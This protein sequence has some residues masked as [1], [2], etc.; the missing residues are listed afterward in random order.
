MAGIRFS[1]NTD[2]EAFILISPVV[3]PVYI[4]GRKMSKD[5]RR[6]HSE[7][8]HQV[9]EEEAGKKSVFCFLPAFDCSN[10]EYLE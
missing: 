1:S 3:W 5:T 10:T 8:I 9:L 7:T 4:A 2:F 6:K